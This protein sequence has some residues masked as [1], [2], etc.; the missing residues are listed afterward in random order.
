[1]PPEQAAAIK[2]HGARITGA[3]FKPEG[4]VIVHSCEAAAPAAAPAPASPPDPYEGALERAGYPVE[5]L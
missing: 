1:M 5:L 4:V 2:E 3:T